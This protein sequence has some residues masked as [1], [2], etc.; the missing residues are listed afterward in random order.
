MSIHRTAIVSP[1]ARIASDV[2]RAV[3]LGGRRVHADEFARA[4]VGDPHE[5]GA[6][7]DVGGLRTD[8]DRHDLD[9]LLV[10][11]TAAAG[12]ERQR[13]RKCERTQPGGS[14]SHDSAQP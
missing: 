7:R 3:D 11:I 12:R 14:P 2:D 10:G 9:G 1:E 5:V 8:R 6:E 13:D 4:A